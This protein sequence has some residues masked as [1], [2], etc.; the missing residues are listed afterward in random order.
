MSRKNKHADRAEFA[1]GIQ[2]MKEGRG[3]NMNPYLYDKNPLTGVPPKKAPENIPHLAWK[4]GHEAAQK[5]AAGAPPEKRV[6]GSRKLLVRYNF[7]DAER[8]A[9]G[10]KITE[11]QRTI[12]IAE[13]QKKRAATQFKSRIEGATAERDEAMEAFRTGYEMREVECKCFADD[14]APGIKTFYREDNG[15]KVRSEEMSAEDKQLPLP[16]GGAGAEGGA[17][18]PGGAAGTGGEDAPPSP[19]D[20]FGPEFDDDHDDI[21]NSDDF[22]SNSG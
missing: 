3:I 22:T 12:D 1:E 4:A 5:E 9:L 20:I 16:L 11:A 18:R 19:D 17:D 7:S 6:L 21:I 13:D 8:L 14:P 15:E 10:G 2:A